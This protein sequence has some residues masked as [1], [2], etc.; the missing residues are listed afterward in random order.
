M[1]SFSIRPVL[2]EDLEILIALYVA[3]F[4]EPPWCEAFLP[5]EVRADF[6]VILS[7]PETIFLVAEDD[8]GQVIGAG[9][10][11]HACR[12]ADVWRLLPGADL[13]QSFYV[14]ELFVDPSART[15]GVC[16]S[17]TEALIDR[18]RTGGFRALSVRTSVDQM[19]V[20]RL[21][22]EM[23]GCREVATEEVVSRKMIGGEPVDV[24]DTRVLMAR[25]SL[26]DSN[27]ES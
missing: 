4:R 8:A 11:F 27:R 3:C 21:F 22:V 1:H 26:P 9:I 24:P 19:V 12:K 2:L 17:L 16:R 5:E 20:R 7:W 18:A 10:G 14:A 13:R 15:R 25:A 23:L 6:D